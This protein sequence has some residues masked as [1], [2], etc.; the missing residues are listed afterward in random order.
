MISMCGRNFVNKGS[1]FKPFLLYFTDIKISFLQSMVIKEVQ[2]LKV[3]SNEKQGGS[4]RW[5][6]LSSGLGP[7]RSTFFFSLNMQFLSNKCI[8]ISA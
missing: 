3:V 7:R 5:R 1:Q 8:S 4:A 6:L 2:C